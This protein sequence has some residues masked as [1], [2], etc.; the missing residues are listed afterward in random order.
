MSALGVVDLHRLAG[1]L[2]ERAAAASAGRAART[3]PHP[4]DGLRQTVIALRG[5]AVL[6]EHD[7]PGAAS[8]LVLRGRVRLIAGDDVA[9][10]A[11]HQAAPIPDRRHSVAADEDSV[12]LLSVAVPA[13]P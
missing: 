7:S 4:V 9:E 1:E 2:L 10:L 6:D 8:L 11:T 13:H 3:L 12:L 5:G